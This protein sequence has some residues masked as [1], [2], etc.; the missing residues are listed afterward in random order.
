MKPSGSGFSFLASCII[1][2]SIYLLQVYSDFL[3][4]RESVLAICIFL[5]IGPFHL[6]YLICWHFTV[7]S[8]PL[9]FFLFRNVSS[10]VPTFIPD[11]GNLNFSSFFFSLTKGLSLFSK[12][13]NQNPAFGFTDFFYYLF[14][15]LFISILNFII[16]FLLPALGLVCSSSPV[17]LRW[18]ARLLILVL[19][20]RYSYLKKLSRKLGGEIRKLE[21]KLI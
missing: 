4:H 8:I 16:S 2:N 14:S 10:N 9:K 5:K 15:L 21:K 13:S 18:K 7:H 11:S 1:T 20:I 6:N 3:I 19:L 12:N 17:L